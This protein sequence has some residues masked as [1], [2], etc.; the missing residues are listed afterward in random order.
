M[1]TNKMSSSSRQE[2]KDTDDLQFLNIPQESGKEKFK[3]KMKENPFV[4]LGGPY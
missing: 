1:Y 3:R 2:L 4:P